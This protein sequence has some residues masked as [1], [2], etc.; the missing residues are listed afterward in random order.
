[1]SPVIEPDSKYIRDLAQR[2]G[3][4]ILSRF[5]KHNP[6]QVKGNFKGIVTEA[7]LEA[8]RLILERIKQDFGHHLI[9]A[10]ESGIK[11]SL[12]PEKTQSVWL[13]DPL[14]GTHNFAHG[15]VY[16]A[17]SI[18]YGITKGSS[19]LPQ[20]A[21]VYAP[22]L[23]DMYWADRGQGSFCNGERLQ[24]SELE[25]FSAGSFSTGWGARRDSRLQKILQEIYAIQ[26]QTPNGGVRVNGAAALDLAQVARGL[27]NGFWETNL[28][29]WDTG[30]GALI[31][32]EAGG[33]LTNFG[34]EPF[35]ALCDR[36]VLA[37]NQAIHRRLLDLIQ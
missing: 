3:E 5:R 30:A 2:A 16:F 21:A 15:L 1:M 20:A 11:G 19:F 36:D 35:D 34:G 7:D 17:V 18:A 26:N 31:V 28:N 8:E 37:S 24:V 14:D 22:A 25:D 10:E 6:S 27:S 23:G 4:A 32:S 33:R 13:V 9:I 29:P 12:D